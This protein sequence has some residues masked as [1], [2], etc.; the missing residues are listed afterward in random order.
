MA[1]RKVDWRG[2]ELWIVRAS[3]RYEVKVGPPLRDL[4]ATESHALAH[5]QR[6]IG[7][8]GGSPLEAITKLLVVRDGFVMGAWEPSEMRHSRE[9]VA[10]VAQDIL[11][12]G[13]SL[14]MQCSE[15]LLG[16]LAGFAQ[17]RLQGDATAM[18]FVA[19]RESASL[20]GI[21]ST[22]H[23]TL[24][25]RGMDARDGEDGTAQDERDFLGATGDE[26]AEVAE[27]AEEAE[28]MART[29][30]AEVDALEREAELEGCGEALQVRDPVCANQ[31]VTVGD[32]EASSEV[33][34]EQMVV[35]SSAGREQGHP[36]DVSEEPNP[37]RT[38]I[39]EE[40]REAPSTLPY[41]G[42]ESASEI[43]RADQFIHDARTAWQQTK[44]PNRHPGDTCMQR[45]S[46]RQV[47]TQQ[48]GTDLRTL[49]L[50]SASEE[51]AVCDDDAPSRRHETGTSASLKPNIE[52]ARGRWG[53]MQ[54]VIA[55]VAAPRAA[56]TK[57]IAQPRR[58]GRLK[59]AEEG[60]PA[61]IVP[62]VGHLQRL[63][64]LRMRT[65]QARTMW[66]TAGPLQALR[67]VGTHS[68]QTLSLSVLCAISGRQTALGAEE[69]AMALALA[70][71]LLVAG[72]AAAALK[73]VAALLRAVRDAR[74]ERSATAA[75]E[76]SISDA[77]QDNLI[78]EARSVC[79]RLDELRVTKEIAKGSTFDEQ[80]AFGQALALAREVGRE[81][82]LSFGDGNTKAQ[83]GAIGLEKPGSS[84]VSG[85]RAW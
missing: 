57:P 52:P 77:T 38:A 80:F 9:H 73:P 7:D 23:E 81:A 8:D 28:T 49:R 48:E 42:E 79:A 50:T 72:T 3:S 55:P 47:F 26:E 78:R 69:L 19:I 70:R 65:V 75:L 39:G 66:Q 4:P 29:R 82:M 13:A 35:P 10:C 44:D 22:M 54:P 30:L 40:V 41:G 76:S 58:G 18:P 21:P 1:Q 62:P 60:G 33:E 12:R 64:Q 25:G 20:G 46:T 27:E 32:E 14:P 6:T 59:R 5:V 37:D 16:L 85:R 68:D 83:A 51:N 67:L 56:S 36:V 2:P 34:S 17:R 24:E 74:P 53:K 45:I 11:P 71:P 61:E 43:V 31:E 84:Q 63:E 15:E